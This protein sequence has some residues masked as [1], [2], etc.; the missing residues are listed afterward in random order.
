[1]RE[2][3]RRYARQAHRL[4]AASDAARRRHSRERKPEPKQLSKRERALVFAKSIARRAAGIGC[5][6]PS[7][8]APPR[9]PSAAPP[10]APR[11]AAVRAPTTSRRTR[12]GEAGAWWGTGSCRRTW[13]V[14]RSSGARLKGQSESWGNSVRAARRRWVSCTQ[15][16]CSG[17]CSC[18][19]VG[20]G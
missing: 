20:C 17:T 6:C 13:T 4:N 18:R 10:P 7:P 12:R 9:A 5:A 1:M 3:A 16:A 15:G 2:R 14:T 19:R 8:T 11:R